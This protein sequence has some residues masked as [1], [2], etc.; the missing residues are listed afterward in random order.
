MAWTA[1]AAL[2][3]RRTESR[4]RF[5]CFIRGLLSVLNTFHPDACGLLGQRDSL[6]FPLTASDRAGADAHPRMI[7]VKTVAEVLDAVRCLARSRWR[8]QGGGEKLSRHSICRLSPAFHRWIL[9]KCRWLNLA[10]LC[11]A[12][13][14]IRCQLV[15]GRSSRRDGRQYVV[16]AS[17]PLR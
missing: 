1:A 17:K 14:K 7:S 11:T 12:V 6:D 3:P 13:S 9:T 16:R 8:R 15:A 4:D 10:V 5:A 2:S